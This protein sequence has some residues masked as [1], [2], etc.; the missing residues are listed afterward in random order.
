MERCEDTLLSIVI[1]AYGRSSLL[2]RAIQSVL[3][4][5]GSH[6]VEILVVD[7]CSP[8]P[9]QCVS[10]RDQD[11]IIRLA[12]NKGAA[13]CRNVGIEQAHSDVISF[14]DSDDYYIKRN[15][16]DDARLANENVNTLYFFSIYSQLFESEYP[17]VVCVGQFFESIFY[18]H[19]HIGQT[20]SLMFNRRSL[21]KFDE[22]LPKHQDWDFF[23]RFLVEVGPAKKGNGTVYFDR[24][25]Q[26][27]LSRKFSPDKSYP[28][29]RKLVDRGVDDLS[30][31]NYHLFCLSPVEYPWGRFFKT[32]IQLIFNGHLKPVKF[33]KYF[34]RK[35]LA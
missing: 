30:Y 9:V 12:E 4:C 22:K 3:S 25:D 17:D 19:P 16:Y 8:E 7:D 26:S 6:L 11:R 20:S 27:S 5:T 32:S 34:I 13:Y 23:Y 29:F 15:F 35:V 10:L 14:L 1:P 2:E 31:I 28:W 33:L 21:H 24:S 18:K